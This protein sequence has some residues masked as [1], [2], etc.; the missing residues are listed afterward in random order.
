[1]DTSKRTNLFLYGGKSKWTVQVL[2]LVDRVGW[3]ISSNIYRRKRY[4]REQKRRVRKRKHN[5]AF[6][7]WG[8]NWSCTNR[9][10]GKKRRTLQQL[11]SSRLRLRA[12]LYNHWKT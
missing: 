8:Q 12:T 3:E 9:P 6:R 5:G 4:V 11:Q 2:R 1:M 10:R 7:E